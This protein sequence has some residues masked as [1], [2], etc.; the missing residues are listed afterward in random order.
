[1]EDQCRKIL[2]EEKDNHYAYYQLAVLN[3]AK[4]NIKE[5]KRYLLKVQEIKPEFNNEKINKS[6][7]EIFESED[8]MELA[9]KHYK[10]AYI[11]TKNQFEIVL[12]IGR[13]YEKLQEKDN[14]ILSYETAI[15]LDNKND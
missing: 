4:H 1:L 11:Y 6:L 12:K 7:G 13:C 3:F 9:I 8:E 5:T 14:I 10:S 15:L 2:E